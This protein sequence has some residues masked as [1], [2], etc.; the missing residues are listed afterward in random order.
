MDKNLSKLTKE[1]KDI[2]QNLI[3]EQNADIDHC[4]ICGDSCE[5]TILI[6]ICN[7]DNSNKFLCKDCMELQTTMYGVKFSIIINNRACIMKKFNKST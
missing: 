3:Q 4:T 7:F 1:E 5:D 6:Y 2:Y